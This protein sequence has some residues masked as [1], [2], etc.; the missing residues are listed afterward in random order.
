MPPRPTLRHEDS[1]HYLTLPLLIG[2]IAWNTTKLR[3]SKGAAAAGA[4]LIAVGGRSACLGIFNN[5]LGTMFGRLIE[6]CQWV[7]P[8]VDALNLQLVVDFGD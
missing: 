1:P 4:G 3:L 2:S 8:H 7:I 6:E 5:N